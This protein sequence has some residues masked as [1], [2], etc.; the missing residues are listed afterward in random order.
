MRSV[1]LIMD[2]FNGK[3]IFCKEWAGYHYILLTTTV[4]VFS[5]KIRT[6]PK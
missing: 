1:F 2:I 3:Q 5:S 4:D 6:S